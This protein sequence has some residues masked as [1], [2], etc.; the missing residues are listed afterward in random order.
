MYPRLFEPVDLGIA[1]LP[2]RIIMGSM[3]TGLEARP[4]GMERLAAA[5][6]AS[7]SSSPAP[8]HL[9]SSPEAAALN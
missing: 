5:I 1:V 4:D 7:R 9:G 3:H 8:R 6:E 2:N